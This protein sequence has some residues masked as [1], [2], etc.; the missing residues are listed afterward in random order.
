M[1]VGQDIAFGANNDATAQAHLWAIVFAVTVKKSEP[2][3]IG[4]RVSSPR[5]GGRN[6]DHRRC[7]TFCCRAHAAWHDGAWRIGSRLQQ[8]HALQRGAA[9]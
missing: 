8:G 3:V 5:L 9:V 6:A 2:R 4:H 1:V 7:R